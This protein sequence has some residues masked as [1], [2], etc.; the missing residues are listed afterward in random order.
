MNKK[1]EEP[2]ILESLFFTISIVSI[3]GWIGY[4]IISTI[5]F[6]DDTQSDIDKI[7]KDINFIEKRLDGMDYV[8]FKKIQ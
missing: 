5:I 6:I 8:Y 4:I 2:E 1:N 7:N 3:L